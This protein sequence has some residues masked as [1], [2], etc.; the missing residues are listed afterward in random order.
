MNYESCGDGRFNLTPVRARVADV[1]LLRCHCIDIEPLHS[2]GH[3]WRGK[4][5][6]RVCWDVADTSRGV[7]R[8]MILPRSMRLPGT[9][10][11]GK[12][13]LERMVLMNASACG[14][15]LMKHSRRAWHRVPVGSNRF[16]I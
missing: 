13:T 9:T 2:R 16:R 6:N 3:G 10:A 15:S 8:T 11:V 5:V 7:V 4:A 12:W 1:P 14:L